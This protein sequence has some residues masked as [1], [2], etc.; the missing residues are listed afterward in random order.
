VP[1][2]GPWSITVPGAVDAF[3]ALLER[4]GTRSLADCLAPAIDAAK[5][6]F[7]A[8][9]VIATSW[10]ALS[11]YA[12]LPPPREGD[13]V[14]M[15][16]LAGSLQRLAAAGRG[17][18]YGGALGDAIARG[19]QAAGGVLSAEDLA[20][21][22]GAWVEPLVIGYRGARVAELPP[23]GQGVTALLALRILEGLDLR[24]RAWDDPLGWHARVEAVKRAMTER[25]AHVADP[26]AMHVTAEDLVSDAFVARCRARVDLDRA[27]RT[28]GPVPPRG[29][30][31]Y[32]ATADRQGNLVSLISSLF[33]GFG[34]GVVAGDT[35]IVMQDRAHGFAPAGDHPNA[36]GPRK[37]PMHTII[38]AMLM[39]ADGTPHTAF[40]VMGGDMQAQGHVQ[41]VSHVCDHGF[42]PQ[43]ALDAPRFRWMGGARVALEEGV[44]DTVRL[45][46]SARGH[47]VSIG[48]SF[49][50]GQA[51]CRLPTGA[52]A[53]AS[54]PRKDGCALAY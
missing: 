53:A 21:H 33:H 9:E 17:E 52:L 3:D 41:Y 48:G 27:D 24:R 47:D 20:A 32:L 28:P 2:R 38:P 40:G 7:V 10:A 15:P 44:P 6:G 14:Q 37:R 26:T 11:A 50:G 31:V 49:G 23:P 36:V 22:R 16:A 43:A 18:M 29:G 51:I 13:V 54:D 8:T 1:E 25:D 42:G 34:S 4:L 30:T 19:V 12:P 46:L 35:G 45:A 39:G 5:G